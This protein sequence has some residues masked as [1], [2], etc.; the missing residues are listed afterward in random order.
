M[1]QTEYVIKARAKTGKLVESTLVASSEED[2]LTRV[3]GLGMTPIAVEVVSKK[4]LR[5][6]IQLTKPRVKLKD[7]SI[8]ARQFATMLSSGLP[9]LR[10]L[11]ILSEQTQNPTLRDILSTVTSD[12]ERGDSL[13]EA[14]VKHKEFPPLMI[15]MIRAGEVGGFLDTTMLQLAE[16]FESDV[17]LRGKIKAALTYPIAVAIIAVL[18]AIAM[19][20]F[21]VPIFSEM[22]A[23][24]GG[25]LPAPTQFLVNASNAIK[26]PL[27]SLPILVVIVAGAWWYR[28]NKHNSR[29][30]NVVD[31]LKFRI[32][33]FGG[34]FQKIALARFARTLSTLLAAGVPVLTALDIVG[35][36]AG[37]IVISRAVTAVKESVRQGSGMATP[38]AE[39]P[40]FPEMVIQMIAVGE[41]TG[42]V[43]QMLRKVADFYDQE[44]EATTEQ[45]MALIEPIMIVFLGGMVGAM[46]IALYLPIFKIFELIK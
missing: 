16:S 39:H 31:P 42:S 44:V 35:D 13:S 40:V 41:D 37:N 36:T 18:I 11:S 6:D 2:A 24:F 30:R 5:R 1:P 46:I 25:S 32:P 7:L 21:V 9:I 10:C 33:V 17:M 34:L 15:S 45:L 20:I 22:F 23:S 43:D 14:M 8:F 28:R 26:N 27:I 38:L 29:V 12:V 3:R 19:L 4:G